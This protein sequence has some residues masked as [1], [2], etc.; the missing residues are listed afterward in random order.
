MRIA[1]TPP[2]YCC[3][4][5]SDCVGKVTIDFE[6]YYDGPV[7][8]AEHYKYQVDDLYLC[9]DCIKT[10]GRLV[11]MGDI[12]ALKVENNELGEAF[13]VKLEEIE[14]LRNYAKGLKEALDEAS[15][16]KIMG[17]MEPLKKGK[18]VEAVK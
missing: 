13:N 5:H 15:S 14:S 10:A 1:E 16:D 6:A 11:G 8:E 7:L 9:E 17:P 12:E 4:C 3:C 18:I 2:P